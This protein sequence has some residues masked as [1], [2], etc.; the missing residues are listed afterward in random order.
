MLVISQKMDSRM[1]LP[2][3]TTPSIEPMK[4]RRKAKKRGMG[5]SVDM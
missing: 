3:R 4:A 5:S 2:D 1:T